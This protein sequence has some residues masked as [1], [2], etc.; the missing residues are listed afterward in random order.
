MWKIGGGYLVL[1]AG[2]A[3][4]MRKGHGAERRDRMLVAGKERVSAQGVRYIARA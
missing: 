1:A 4:V 3:E 2:N